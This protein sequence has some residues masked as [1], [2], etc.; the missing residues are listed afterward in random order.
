MYEQLRKEVD[1]E[2]KHHQVG[3]PHAASLAHIFWTIV[4]VKGQYGSDEFYYIPYIP[5]LRYLNQIIKTV[6]IFSSH[7]HMKGI[8]S[9]KLSSTVLLFF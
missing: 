5:L 3:Y 4:A 7:L 8:R 9:M 6:R 1:W 2:H